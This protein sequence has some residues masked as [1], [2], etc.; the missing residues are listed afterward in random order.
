MATE[1]PPPRTGPNWP[2]II[3]IALLAILLIVWLVN[4][5]GDRDEAGIEDPIV[6]PDPAVPGAG[7]TGV[8]LPEAGAAAPEAGQPA[9]EAG[10]TAAGTPGGEPIRGTTDNEPPPPPTQ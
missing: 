8:G 2:W 3:V 1:P 9:A 5:S 4:P 10:A 7:A 6:V